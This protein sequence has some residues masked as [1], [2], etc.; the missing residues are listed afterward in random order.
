VLDGLALSPVQVDALKESNSAATA[1]TPVGEDQ[2]YGARDYL[3]AGAGQND[4]AALYGSV[5]VL[6]SNAAWQDS[7]ATRA[8]GAALLVREGIDPRG[9]LPPGRLAGL[10]RNF[11]Q[12]AAVPAD[13]GARL[14]AL[15]VAQYPLLGPERGERRVRELLAADDAGMWRMID[16]DT[17]AYL[18]VKIPRFFPLDAILCVEISEADRSEFVER[19]GARAA[20]LLPLRPL[21]G[22]RGS[23]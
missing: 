5:S 7:F 19:A 14:A 8:S 6:L 12:D 9:E 10:R 4:E 2:L 15:A 21:G 18:E 20:L 16:E 13:Y 22:C 23:L 1:R 17:D 3:F 11:V